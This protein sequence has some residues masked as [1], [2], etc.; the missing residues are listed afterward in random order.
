MNKDILHLCF[1]VRCLR[2]VRRRRINSCWNFS[3]IV[4]F[5]Y[6]C[7]VQTSNW[8]NRIISQAYGN[9]S[10]FN[11]F[12][13]LPSEESARSDAWLRHFRK[14]FRFGQRQSQVGLF[15]RSFVQSATLATQQISPSH[16]DRRDVERKEG[17]RILAYVRHGR[18]RI[19]NARWFIVCSRR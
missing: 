11:A 3:S 15:P 7:P 19:T 18:R 8:L 2:S 4:D 16:D 10:I 6:P 13:F 9:T 5:T 1:C 14:Y 17:R 12:T